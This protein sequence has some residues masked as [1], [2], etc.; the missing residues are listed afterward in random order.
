MRTC[1]SAGLSQAVESIEWVAA[2]PLFVSSYSGDVCRPA[3]V[4]GGRSQSGGGVRHYGMTMNLEI[5]FD[6]ERSRLTAIAARIL[7]SQHDAGDVI[8]E[9]W[10]RLS[11]SDIDEIDSLPGWLT[12]VVTRL[13]LDHLRKRATRTEIESSASVGS[14]PVDPVDDSLLADQV[15]G[16]MQVVMDSLAPAERVAFVLHDVFGY[17]F[18]DI[19]ALLGRTGTA[20]R[21]LASRARHKLQDAPE[22]SEEKTARDDHEQVVGAFLTAARGGEMADMMA[23]L[24]PDAVMRA[25]AVGIEMGTDPIYDGAAAVAERFN[26]AKGAVPVTIDGDLGAAWIAATEVKVAFVFHVTGGLVREVELLA[27]PEILATIAVQ[28]RRREP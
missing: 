14:P 21:K 23:L 19:S 5:A 3:D 24:A 8:Q 1:G 15:G 25:D 7:G 4:T 22:T 16:A 17:P 10:L 2:A 20:T 13:C 12:T 26:G 9:A 6:A 18:E 11:R 28:R 27:D